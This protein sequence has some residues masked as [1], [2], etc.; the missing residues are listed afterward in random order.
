MSGSEGG[1]TLLEFETSGFIQ[2]NQAPW[3]K[4]WHAKQ[5]FVVWWL[6][7]VEWTSI[8]FVI[9]GDINR[10]TPIADD[11]PTVLITSPTADDAYWWDVVLP[12]IR[13]LCPEFNVELLCCEKEGLSPIAKEVQHPRT[14]IKGK[15]FFDDSIGARGSTISGSLGAVVTLEREGVK[16]GTFGLSA[17][18]AVT[19]LGIEKACNGDSLAPDN[20]LLQD[21]E[22][23]TCSPLQPDFEAYGQVLQKELVTHQSNE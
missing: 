23:L 1:G 16:Q 2:F 19:N 20:A 12:S 3:I 6:T 11:R 15:V 18:S 7:E 4:L 21:Q 17:N 10:P 5:N 13:L 9:R 8:D 14:P 22:Q